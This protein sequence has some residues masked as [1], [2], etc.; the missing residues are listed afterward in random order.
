MESTPVMINN[1]PALTKAS[2]LGPRLIN[3]GEVGTYSILLDNVTNEDV[4]AN[5]DIQFLQRQADK[6]DIALSTKQVTIPAGQ[7][8]ATFA[9]Q[10]TLKLCK[11]KF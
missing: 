1:K 11:A 6:D 8:Q 4:V 9:I 7:K 2:L 10:E 3:E 5:I